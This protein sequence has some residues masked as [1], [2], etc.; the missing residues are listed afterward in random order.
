MRNVLGHYSTGKTSLP[1]VQGGGAAEGIEFIPR[2]YFVLDLRKYI[3]VSITDSCLRQETCCYKYLKCVLS[4]SLVRKHP[5]YLG[6]GA[7]RF[8][9]SERSALTRLRSIFIE[10]G[11]LRCF[12]SQKRRLQQVL[13]KSVNMS[14]HPYEDIRWRGCS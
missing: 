6:T 10:V 3:A 1:V 11:G 9:D 2:C 13:L 14:S 5:P 7:S 12:S 4:A 8:S